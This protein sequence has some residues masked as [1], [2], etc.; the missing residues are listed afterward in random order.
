[1]TAKESKAVA[2]R[3][4]DRHDAEAD[5]WNYLDLPPLM[6]YDYVEPL[7]LQ[8]ALHDA[9]AERDAFRKELLLMEHKVITCG[10]AASHPDKLLT[11]HG[12]YKTKWDSTQ[13]QSVR[14]LRDAKDAAEAELGELRRR[15]GELAGRLGNFGF[16]LTES[17]QEQLLFLIAEL[18]L[19]ASD[20]GADG[21]CNHEWAEGYGVPAYCQHCG[22]TK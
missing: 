19:L 22:V 17:R 2:W 15:V 6:T 7:V 4:R 16:T 11:T 12:A 8:S 9:E 13:A 10:V 20:G 3:Y 1:M 18:K 21:V 5:V 14:E